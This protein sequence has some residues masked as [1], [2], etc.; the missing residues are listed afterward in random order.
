MSEIYVN[1]SGGVDVTQAKPLPENAATCFFGVM[2]AGDFDIEDQQAR[3]MLLLPNPHG[4]PN[5]DVLRPR[6]TARDILQR[7]GKGWIIDFGCTIPADAGANYE[8]P[9]EHLEKHVKSV[10]EQ[11]R[12]SRMAERWWLHGE[13]RPGMRRSME[14]LKRFIVTPEVSKYRVFVWL[15]GVYLADHQTRA[16]ARDDDYAFGV[17]HCRVHELWARAQ[18]TQLRESESGFRYT[19]S[20]CFE[21]FP[22]PT[23]TEAQKAVI[24]EAAASLNAMREAWLNP[25]E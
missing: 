20:T 17:L 8:A 15:D 10:R 14:G 7:G 22:F 6:L 13:T 18:G 9:W 19:P 25:T 23:P 5:S 11:N 24:S 21:T 3:T 16:I 2:K 4:R 12:R 1:L